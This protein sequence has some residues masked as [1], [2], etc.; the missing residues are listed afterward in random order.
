MRTARLREGGGGGGG[1]GLKERRRMEE[2]VEL[3]E[4]Y[5]SGENSSRG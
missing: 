2:A 5:D 3:R 1:G 4:N